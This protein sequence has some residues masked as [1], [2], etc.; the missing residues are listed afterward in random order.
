MQRPVHTYSI[1]ARDPATG[2]LGAAVQS[3]WFAVGTLCLWVEAEIGA[4]ATQALVDPGYGMLGLELMRAGKSAPDA[5]RGLLAADEASETRQVAM[6]DAMG[7]VSAHTGGKTIQAAGHRLGKG[8]SVQANMMLNDRVWPAMA[9]AFESAAGDLAGRMIAALEAGQD[10]GGDVRGQQSAAL[11]VVTGKP[12]GHPWLDRSFD[13]RV[14]DHPAPLEELRRLVELQR[15][16]NHMNAGDRAMETRDHRRALEEYATAAR[17][18]PGNV[19]IVY[20]HAVALVNMQRVD[21]ALPL[22]R[23]VFTQDRNWVTLTPRLAEAELLPND[24]H[25]IARICA[26]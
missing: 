7:R 23:S 3:H 5:L 2:E 24:P 18:A 21:D 4:V 9:E 1:V 20:W 13:L 10:A 25:L 14:D 12:T 26:A 17:L 6:I 22:F 16:Y 8:Y 11:V 19:E 15:A